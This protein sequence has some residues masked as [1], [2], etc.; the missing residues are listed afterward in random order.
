M[1]KSTHYSWDI[2]KKT[3]MIPVVFLLVFSAVAV[4]LSI[5]LNNVFYPFN[6]LYIGGA[7][8]IGIFLFSAMP[9]K[10]KPLGRKISQLLVGLYMLIFLGFIQGENMQIEGFGIYIASGLFAGATIHYLIAKVAGPLLFNRG[11]CGWAC[12]AAMVLDFLPFKNTQKSP[13]KKARSNSIRAFPYD[14]CIRD[15]CI[16]YA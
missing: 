15:H 3:L 1:S 12:W 16:F 7:V 14:N 2:G 10:L 9:K 11:W 6:Y 4:V 13:L 5:T 8:S